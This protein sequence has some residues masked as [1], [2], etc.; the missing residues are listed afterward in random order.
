MIN[1][2]KLLIDIGIHGY[3]GYLSSFLFLNYIINKEYAASLIIICLISISSE[4]ICFFLL[5]YTI[6]CFMVKRNGLKI[7]EILNLKSIS[8]KSYSIY[9]LLLMMRLVSIN[10]NS[11]FLFVIDHFL[12]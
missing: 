3:I 10:C 7:D 1:T 4:V 12:I 9:G 2:V 5:R 11:Y 8:N 6:K